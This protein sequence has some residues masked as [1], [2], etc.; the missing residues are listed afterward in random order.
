MPGGVE[1]VLDERRHLS[2]RPRGAAVVCVHCRQRGFCWSER[3]VLNGCPSL[4]MDWQDII[5]NAR[6]AP[7]TPNPGH[8]ASSRLLQGVPLDATLLHPKRLWRRRDAVCEHRQLGSV[9]GHA[10]H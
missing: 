1:S 6:Q 8:S 4:R 10:R 2:L 9:Q 5:P 7:Q 3:S